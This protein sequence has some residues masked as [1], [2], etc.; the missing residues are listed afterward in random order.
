M[1]EGDLAAMLVDSRREVLRA[2]EEFDDNYR[3]KNINGEDWAN[4]IKDGR[5]KYSIFYK[6]KLYPVKIIVSIASGEKR[7]DFY[8]GEQSYGVLI[9][10]DFDI[11]LITD[12]SSVL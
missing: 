11:I 6:G 3:G 1:I 8:G 7:T 10:L 5:H 12:G 9:D 4:W 2:M